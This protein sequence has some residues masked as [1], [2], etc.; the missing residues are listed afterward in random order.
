MRSLMN[1]QV[2]YLQS[3]AIP[4]I[5]ITDEGDPETV[6]Q[7]INGVYN[8]IYCSPEC[9]LSVPIWRGIFQCENFKKMLIS[10]AIDEAHC[11]VQ[12]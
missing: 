5:E 4:A 3:V 7:V 9:L 6:Q 12:W 8:V 11:I 2:Q 1:D 10:V